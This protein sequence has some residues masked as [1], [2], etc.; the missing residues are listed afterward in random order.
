MNAEQI[1][2]RYIADVKS[3]LPRRALS[4]VPEELRSLLLESAQERA[5]DSGRALD[6]ELMLAVVRQFGHPEEVAQRYAGRK[7]HL[8]GPEFFPLYR[9][10]VTIVMAVAATG[11]AVVSMVRSQ[12]LEDV[13]TGALH[14]ALLNFAVLTV[15]F[16]VLER[17]DARHAKARVPKLWIPAEEPPAKDPDAVDP[18]GIAF[19]LYAII[20]VA[21]LLNFRLEWFFF[22]SGDFEVFVPLLNL[23]WAGAFAMNLWNLHHRRWTTESRVVE[24]TLGL[25]GIFI[26]Y[27]IFQAR[28]FSGIGYLLIPILPVAIIIALIDSVLRAYRVLRRFETPQTARAR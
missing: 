8:I 10:V 24:L 12:P 27:L 25:Y 21:Y 26:A 23:F 16:A 15:V 11:A 18:S 4:D 9:I 3:R 5:A 19:K 17:I 1:L 13:L 2:D 6:G 20:T 14:L 7:N 22:L 28:P